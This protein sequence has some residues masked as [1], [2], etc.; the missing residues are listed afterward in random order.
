M[1]KYESIMWV[2]E[3]QDDNVD[4]IQDSNELKEI[5]D[6]EGL[7][8]DDYNYG[9]IVWDEERSGQIQ[10]IYGSYSASLDA[11]AYQCESVLDQKFKS[12]CSKCNVTY[13]GDKELKCPQC[14]LVLW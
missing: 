10:H 1:R 7:I 9:F 6:T 5:L 11:E 13:Y 3:L 2:R 14:G 12:Y 8:N 4:L